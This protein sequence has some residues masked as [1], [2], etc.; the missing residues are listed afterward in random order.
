MLKVLLEN[1]VNYGIEHEAYFLKI[2]QFLPCFL[3]FQVLGRHIKLTDQIICSTTHREELS[4]MVYR[5]Q[6][7]KQTHRKFCFV[8]H[9]NKWKD[10]K[11]PSYHHRILEQ[12]LRYGFQHLSKSYIEFL[13]LNSD[14]IKIS[15]ENKAKI[16]W[17]NERT[18]ILSHILSEKVILSM[19]SYKYINKRIGRY[20]GKT[21][22]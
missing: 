6:E 5:S 17:D 15:W 1:T 19:S 18:K 7:A 2:S 3:K 11:L 21:I 20:M 4:D 8:I 13:T 16:S 9:S 12:Q 22:L 14:K 10:R